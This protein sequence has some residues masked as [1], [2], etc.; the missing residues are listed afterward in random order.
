LSPGF[1]AAHGC[2]ASDGALRD[3]TVFVV[4]EGVLFLSPQEQHIDGQVE[5]VFVLILFLVGFVHLFEV[6][7]LEDLFGGVLFCFVNVLLVFS[8]LLWLFA[9]L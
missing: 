7:Y 9:L 5:L 4:R 3:I 8:L 6:G 2:G 1:D